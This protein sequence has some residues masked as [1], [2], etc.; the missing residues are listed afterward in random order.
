MVQ[1]YDWSS[2]SSVSIS[3]PFF[4]FPLNAT[5]ASF[6]FSQREF[7]V[8]KSSFVMLLEYRHHP[9]IIGHGRPVGNQFLSELGSGLSTLGNLYLVV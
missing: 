8:L 4:F 5:T 9:A 3:V 1:S 6:M 2:S 7:K